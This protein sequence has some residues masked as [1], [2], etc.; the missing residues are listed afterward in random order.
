MLHTTSSL[1][2]RT[3]CTREALRRSILPAVASSA[4]QPKFAGMVWC[5]ATP[6]PPPS[7]L[8]IGE[9]HRRTFAAASSSGSHDDFAPIKKKEVSDAEEA[10]QLIKEHVQNNPVMVY[11]K[12]NPTTPM[13][14]FSAKVVQILR[15]EGVDFGSVNVLDYPAIREGVK[16]YSEWPTIPQVYVSGE[17]VGGCDIVTAMHES[18]EL[19]ALLQ[20]VPKEEK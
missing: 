8:C 5:C 1:M 11:M 15:E 6:P 20:T 7:A 4:S 18:G 9:H 17:F 16:A 10:I 12:G 13:C 2:L 3:A 14:G 19:A